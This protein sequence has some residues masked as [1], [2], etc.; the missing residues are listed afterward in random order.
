VKTEVVVVVV[1]VVS[2]SLNVMHI[3]LPFNYPHFLLCFIGKV[4]GKHQLCGVIFM[5]TARQNC[6]I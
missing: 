6:P 2:S 3:Q 4:W 1:E 5:S